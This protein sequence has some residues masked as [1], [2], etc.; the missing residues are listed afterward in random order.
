MLVTYTGVICPKIQEILDF[1]KK[2]STSWIH[3]WYDNDEFD[4][5]G[6]YKGKRIVNIG[7]KSCSYIRQDTIRI[8]CYHAMA[9]LI[10][11][12]EQ[13]EKWIHT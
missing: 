8:S 2:Y 9:A 12:R 7:N 3:A 5:S 4:L 11:M 13:L 6:P 10:Y 1:Q